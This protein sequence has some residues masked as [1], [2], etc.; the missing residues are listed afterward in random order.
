MS[1]GNKN[2]IWWKEPLDRFDQVDE[3]TDLALA[4]ITSKTNQK[5]SDL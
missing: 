5:I 2:S 1:T 4:P 3:Q